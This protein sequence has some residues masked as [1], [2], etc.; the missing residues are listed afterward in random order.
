MSYLVSK[1]AYSNNFTLTDVT[2][3]PLTRGTCKM[4]IRNHGPFS[5]KTY[6][7][8]SI[9]ILLCIFFKK[10]SFM[11]YHSI[12]YSNFY[13]LLALDLHFYH[14]LLIFWLIILQLLHNTEWLPICWCAVEKL[15]FLVLN[16]HRW[17]ACQKQTS[18]C[19][20]VT[21]FTFSL[22]LIWLLFFFLCFFYC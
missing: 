9:I 1:Q 18:A 15:L 12:C 2:V 21:A 10:P 4:L 17:S 20:Y 3:A 19:Y 11:I 14:Y 13:Q 22:D 16:T 6:P 8:P 5:R 7:K